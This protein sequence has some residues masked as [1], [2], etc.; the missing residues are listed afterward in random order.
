MKHFHFLAHGLDVDPLVLKIRQNPHLWQEDDYLRK[1]PQ[2]PFGEVESIML[3]FP[4][5][6]GVIPDEDLELYKQN[7]LPGHDQHE[8]IDYPAYSVL[9]E[10][11]PLVMT[12]MARVQGERL[13]RVMINKVKPGG[14]IFPHEDTPEHVAYYKRYHIV[15]QGLPG[16]VLK[17]A[18][19][20]IDMRTGDCFWFNNALM[21]EVINNSAEERWSMVVDIHTSR[22]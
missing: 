10:A 6:L 18:D 22:P 3:R 5:K 20:Q 15:L 19:E 7:M 9:L 13:G 2:G 16:A 11:R 14:R 17:C 21:H 1:Y 4:K 12:L 8:S